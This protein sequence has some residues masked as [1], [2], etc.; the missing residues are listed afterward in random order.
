MGWFW[1][2]GTLPSAS[3]LPHAGHLAPLLAQHE[4]QE[5]FK[6]YRDLQFLSR[7][8]QGWSRILGVF[9]DMLANRRKAY[10]ERLPQVRAKTPQDTDL[11]ALRQR[12]DRLA[13]ELQRADRRG[14]RRRLLRRHAGR[15]AG[16]P[17]RA[18][19]TRCKRCRADQQPAQR[20]ASACAWR[21]AR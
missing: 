10:A 12:R 11:A 19:A 3:A 1:N 6:N 4:F 14:R 17:G 15:A 8:L 20:R 7:N 2:I 21:R 16:A 13:D 9:G 18:R 5:A